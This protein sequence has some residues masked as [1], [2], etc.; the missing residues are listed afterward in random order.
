MKEEEKD[1]EHQYIKMD[2]E[3]FIK[4]WGKVVTIFISLIYVGQGIRMLNEYQLPLS[5]IVIAIAL[6]FLIWY[7]LFYLVWKN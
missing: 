4:G 3:R 1:L 7:P 2:K 6:S 5:S